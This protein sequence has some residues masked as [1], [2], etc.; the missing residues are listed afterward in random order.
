M[1]QQPCMWLMVVH[2]ADAFTVSFFVGVA[3]GCGF[4]DK[5]SSRAVFHIIPPP[6]PYNGAVSI[7]AVN[8]LIS[9]L[10]IGDAF[11]FLTLL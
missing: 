7:F 6:P 9:D 10:D 3:L 11:G 1:S 5:M 4:F 8:K 2:E